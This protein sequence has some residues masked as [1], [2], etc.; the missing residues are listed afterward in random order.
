M[1]CRAPLARKLGRRHKAWRYSVAAAEFAARSCA[2]TWMAGVAPLGKRA[3]PA[4]PAGPASHQTRGLA[5]A[6]DAEQ[7]AFFEAAAVIA[8]ATL[9]AI[10][11]VATPVIAMAGCG[12]A[13]GGKM[14]LAL[15]PAGVFA[16]VAGAE[17]EAAV[18]VNRGGIDAARGGDRRRARGVGRRGKGEQSCQQHADSFHLRFLSRLLRFAGLLQFR[19]V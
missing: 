5:L 13:R 12:V 15:A 8:A 19:S 7:F 11:A 9:T 17:V 14:A 4:G 3:A 6:A 10:V 16:V 2:A 1:T 18:V